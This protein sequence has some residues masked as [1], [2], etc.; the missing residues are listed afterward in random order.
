MTNV[1]LIYVSERTDPEDA[2]L[3]RDIAIEASQT[4]RTLGVSGILMAVDNF[5]L[6][7]LEGQEDVVDSL[8][9]KI[10]KDERHT[11]VRVL[12]RGALPDRIFGQWSMGCV[13]SNEDIVHSE[14]L[15]SKI[16]AQIEDLCRDLTQ[17]NGEELRDL[18]VRIPRLL[19]E[20]KMAILQ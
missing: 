18:I 15:F 19:G 3:V 4:N 8:L 13:H 6:Q 1:F 9:G 10:G 12:Y 20:G 2:M 5:F 11:D 7:V 16:Q 17:E 14:S